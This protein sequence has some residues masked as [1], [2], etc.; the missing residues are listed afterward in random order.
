M[1]NT[2]TN[3]IVTEP[4]AA[5]FI[6]IGAVPS[7]E[8]LDGGVCRVAQKLA[9]TRQEL[10]L[11]DAARNWKL[12]RDPFLLETS[13]PGVFAAGDVRRGSGKR[14]TMAVGDGAMAVISVWQYRALAGL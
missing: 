5:L 8:W 2:A 6:F 9:L 4:G 1:K 12:D 7:T 11:G 14:I 13:I 3:E 10:R